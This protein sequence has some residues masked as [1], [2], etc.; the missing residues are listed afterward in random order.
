MIKLLNVADVI[1]GS[2]L[3]LLCL[4]K[5]VKLFMDLNHVPL[6]IH[7]PVCVVSQTDRV[8]VHSTRTL[9]NKHVLIVVFQV[10]L[11]VTV[12]I[13]D[14]SHIMDRTGRMCQEGDLLQEIPQ[15][16]VLGMIVG[17]TT[18]YN[19]RF[20]YDHRLYLNL[21]IS[22]N[23]CIRRLSLKLLWLNPMWISHPHLQ[24]HLL[25]HMWRLDPSHRVVC[26]LNLVLKLLLNGFLKLLLPHVQ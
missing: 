10:T 18:R 25:I 21:G 7:A 3:N 15:T 9:R 1:V 26:L 13:N 17:M 8:H 14:M 12:P 22:P 19:P 4:W 23:K 2:F 5:R 16:H 11:P 24:D 6:H 20:L